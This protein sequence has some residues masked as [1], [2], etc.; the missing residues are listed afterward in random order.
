MKPKSTRARS[1]VCHDRWPES[2]KRLVAA[3][4]ALRLPVADL[5]LPVPT[6]LEV[7][8]RH[9]LRKGMTPKK[10][11]EVIH[12]AAVIHEQCAAANVKCVVDMGSGHVSG[13]YSRRQPLPSSFF[14]IATP[15]S[16]ATCARCCTTPTATACW[17]WSPLQPGSR[18][19]S[20]GTPKSAAPWASRRAVACATSSATCR[21]IT[22][23]PSLRRSP[24]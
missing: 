12:L 15:L 3:C 5:P 20:V 13:F 9:A 21:P 7:R 23:G 22:R 14:F 2:L 10:V 16:R 1:Q 19:L 17:A 11:H 8:L 18:S 24:R 4:T 6:Q